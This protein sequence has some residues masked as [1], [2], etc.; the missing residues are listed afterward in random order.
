M[1]RKSFLR[2]FAIAAA[3]GPMVLDACKKSSSSDDG[4]TV[5]TSTST[6]TG[7]TPT[8]EEGPYPYVGGEITNPLQ[9]VDVT[10]GQ[11]GIPLALTL[12]VHNVSSNNA[13]VPNVRVDMWQCNKD[14]YYSGYAGQPGVLGTQS[15][16]GKTWLRGYQLTDATGQ[17]KFTTIYPGWYSGRATHIHLEIF[18]NNVLKKTAQMAFPETISDAVHVSSLYSA[19]GINTTRNATDSVFGNSSTDLANEML[20]ITGSIAAGYTGTYT[21][22]LAL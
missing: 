15:Y 3:A 19:H 22:G 16:V 9:R 2:T 10:D 17:A 6:N 8:E 4:T 7:V 1:E 5:T 14:G 20:S 11:T 18:I 21:I 12:T 13:V